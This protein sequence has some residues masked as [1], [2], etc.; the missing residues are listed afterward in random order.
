MATTV[1][2]QSLNNST[3]ADHRA[4]FKKGI[5][6]LEDLVSDNND[7][8]VKQSPNSSLLTPTKVF[9]LM[10]V[11]DALHV[12][13]WNSLMLCGHKRDKT[14]VQIILSYV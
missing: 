10:Q 9:L 12:Q 7:L 3:R 8:I 11:I 1:S 13:W 14:F 2:V 6:T 4:L 5:I